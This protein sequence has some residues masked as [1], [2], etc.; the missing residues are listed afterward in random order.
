M[1]NNK[2]VVCGEQTKK[3]LLSGYFTHCLKHALIRMKESKKCLTCGNHI[4]EKYDKDFCFQC[5][6]KKFFI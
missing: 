6:M 1:E 4:D 5:K 3:R 2:C